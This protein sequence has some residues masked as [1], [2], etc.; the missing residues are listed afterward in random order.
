[1]EHLKGLALALL[2]NM[3]PGLEML[4]KD[5]HSSLLQTVANEK[6]KKL[7]KIGPGVN[8]NELHLHM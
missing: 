3:R 7:Y 4:D 5:K 1:V 6:H 8:V 2:A